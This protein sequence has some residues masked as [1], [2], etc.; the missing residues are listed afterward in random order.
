MFMMMIDDLFIRISV[1]ATDGRRGHR[2]V[3]GRRGRRGGG[4][5]GQDFT[6]LP[7][8]PDRDVGV[9]SDGDQRYRSNEMDGGRAVGRFQR[10]GMIHTCHH[11]HAVSQLTLGDGGMVR[12]DRRK[13]RCVVW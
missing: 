6:F 3:R 13:G 4:R 5:V 2:V 9:D 10:R 7:D 11:W 12:K 1:P 8:L